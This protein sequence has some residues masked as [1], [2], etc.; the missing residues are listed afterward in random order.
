MAIRTERRARIRSI[1]IFIILATL[2]CYCV[3]LVIFQL[4][5]QAA[6]P[7]ATPSL[8]PTEPFVPILITPS[9]TPSPF[10]LATPTETSTATITWTPTMT[11]TLFVPPTRTETPTLTPTYTP[12][13]TITLIQPTPTEIPPTETPVPPAP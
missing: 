13:P 7:T 9:F 2:P 3:G 11:F 4:G 12:T 5:Q 10:I 6:Q 1:L 8:T